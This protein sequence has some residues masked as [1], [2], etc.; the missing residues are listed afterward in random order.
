MVQAPLLSRLVALRPDK[1][2]A[3]VEHGRERQRRR[4]YAEV[5][6]VRRRARV[7][8]RCRGSASAVAPHRRCRGRRDLGEETAGADVRQVESDATAWLAGNGEEG[9][10]E[11]IAWRRLD[12]VRRGKWLVVPQLKSSLS[13]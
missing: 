11:T 9:N 6:E 5:D 7:H 13:K 2:A 1:V 12:M 8:G 3:R 4:A 10:G